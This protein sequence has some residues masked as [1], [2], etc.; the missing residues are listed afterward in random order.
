[1]LLKVM[2]IR[3]FHASE[4]LVESVARCNECTDISQELIIKGRGISFFFLKKIVLDTEVLFVKNQ[5]VPTL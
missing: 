1:M 5:Y 2:S 3:D 4:N